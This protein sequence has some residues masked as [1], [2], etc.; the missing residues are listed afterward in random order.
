MTD[1][2]KMMIDAEPL[3]EVLVAL[4]GP[5]HLIMELMVTRN[6]PDNPVNRLLE[7]FNAQA[8]PE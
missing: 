4:T 5:S 1:S 2:T 3:R 7:Q 6:F 8:Q